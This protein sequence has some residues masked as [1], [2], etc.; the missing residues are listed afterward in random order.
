[1]TDR[2][3]DYALYIHVPFCVH[4]C[5]YCD[6]NTYAGQES[7]IPAYVE[8]LC[9]ELQYLGAAAPAGSSIRT[10]FFGG[11]TPTLLSAAQFEKILAQIKQ[12][13]H[14]DPA[15]EISVEANPGTV[16][17]DALSALRTAGINRISFG[18]QS[19]HA[20]ELRQLE[21]IHNFFTVIESVTAA[22]QAGFDNL[23][24]DLMYGL[25]GQTLARWQESLR[26]ALRL[27]P[28]HLS[29]YAL[30]LE[31]GTPFAHWVARGLMPAPDADLAA[32]MYLWA[33]GIL[34][35]HG[36]EQYEI[37]NWAKPGRAC[38]HN[39]IYWRS[40]PYL[41]LGAGAHGYASGKRYANVLGIQAYIRRLSQPSA[42][43]AFPVSPAAV[44]QKQLSRQDEMEEMLMMGLR[45]TQEGVSEAAF[46]ARFGLG[47]AEAF[48][49]AVRET[50]ELGLAEWASSPDGPHLRLRPEAYLLGNQVFMRFVGN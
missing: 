26:W 12:A 31:H 43:P 34:R 30:T 5:A 50:Q 11:G 44:Q 20:D 13:F 49:R 19:V 16:Q 45:L 10:V 2:S 24:L 42:P 14:L 6:F 41:G 38:Q 7:R 4:R 25:P 17:P 18:V 32:E 37:S 47:I 22:R 48:P 15:A 9:R 46:R 8:A 27:Q 35:E 33:Q 36:Y 40:Q 28:E 29:L 21:R 39:L 1:M 23:N 3:T